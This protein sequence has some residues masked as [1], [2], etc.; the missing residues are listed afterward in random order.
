[1]MPRRPATAS[2]P[3]RRDAG[4]AG[5]TALLVVMLLIVGG[6]VAYGLVSAA[7]PPAQQTNE[8]QLAAD[9]SNDQPSFAD[10]PF[11]EVEPWSGEIRG[12]Q[13]RVSIGMSRQR[14]VDQFGPPDDEQ[15]NFGRTRD[16]VDV[17]TWYAVGESARMFQAAASTGLI[18][19]VDLDSNRV[20]WFKPPAPGPQQPAD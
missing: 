8:D 7:N 13:G 19:K 4:S 16:G 10:K 6:I 3:T 20:I 11:P 18:V 12:R 14:L 1:M 15:T 5:V 2:R 9:S 17:L